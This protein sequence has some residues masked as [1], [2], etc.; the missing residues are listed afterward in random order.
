MGN[1]ADVSLVRRGMINYTVIRGDTFA[2]PPVSF[3]IGPDF[4]HLSPEDFSGAV[5]LMAVRTDQKRVMKVLTNSDGISVS[6]NI[7]QYTIAAA[8]MEEWTPGIYRYDVQKT[9]SGI[10]S[11]I[12][13]GV[14]NL[15]DDIT[16]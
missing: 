3:D 6:G 14:I 10:V 11:T 4:S 2:P 9:V 13:S 5:L 8:D 1:T 7:L 16:K 12:Q 15:I